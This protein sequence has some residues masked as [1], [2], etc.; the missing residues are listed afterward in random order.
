[1]RLESLSIDAVAQ[2]R[3]SLRILRGMFSPFDKV[4]NV[5]NAKLL[6]AVKYW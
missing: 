3:S 1:M 2:N 4:Q 6:R 5:D